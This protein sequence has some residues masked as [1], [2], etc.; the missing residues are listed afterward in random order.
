MPGAH[1]YMKP[2]KAKAK[3]APAPAKPKRYK[4]VSA[5][6]RLKAKKS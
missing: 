1:Y 5:K 3:A 2:K 6:K 4:A